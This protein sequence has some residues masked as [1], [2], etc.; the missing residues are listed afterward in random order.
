MADD[1]TTAAAA[2]TIEP[3]DDSPGVVAAF[4]SVWRHRRWRWLA[5][6]TVVSLFGDV[7]YVVA[8]A[9]SL[10]DGPNGAVWLAGSFL[11]R[12]VPYVVLGPIGGAIADRIDRRLLMV[13]L[14]FA[15][16]CLFIAMAGVAVTSG[17]RLAMVI[18]LGLNA[19]CGAVFEP[20]RGAAIPQLVPERD[21][22]A[23]NATEQGLS[24]LSWFVGPALGALLVAV[25]NPGI[26][27]AIDA[28]TFFIS[29]VLL[30]RV[31]SL[32]PMPRE[33][34]GA[35]EPAGV[36]ATVIDDIGAGARFAFRDRGLRGLMILSAIAT[37]AFGAE[38]ILYVLVAADRLGLG[39]EGIGYLLT[40]MGVGGIIG[41]PLSARASNSRNI[42]VWLIATG[43]LVSV[44]MVVVSLTDLRWVVFG[45]S[46][47]EGGAAVVFDVVVL[48][49]MQR[50]VPENAMGRVLSLSDALATL[51]Q[52][53][54][55]IGAPLLVSVAGL[56]IALQV[57]G[58]LALAV[59]LITAPALLALAARTE[60]ERRRLNATARHLAVVAELAAFEPIDLERLA[61]ASSPLSVSAGADVITAGDP[62]GDVYV[63]RTGR[64]E[65][66]A[67][68]RPAGAG[69]PPILGAGSLFGEIGILRGIPR[70][71]TVTALDDTELLAI[72]GPVFATV[73]T[74]SPATEQLFG[75]M[76]SRLH[77]THPHLVEPTDA[78][79]P[80]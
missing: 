53:V 43:V 9:V 76:R 8:I 55:A 42:G 29:A 52:T 40:A 58:G 34:S 2:A 17:P 3:D 35:A 67:A 22:A 15:R 31:G 62:P 11:A 7:M 44:P 63:V 57:S 56:T 73:A 61:R 25:S 72:D 12:L 45:M 24:Q 18:L 65:V 60:S 54:G 51:G 1:D 4:R 21:L 37:L 64:L 5:A 77:H 59:V 68:D 27:L 47:I 48:T 66:T 23:A 71:A 74:P 26:V 30:A 36:L 50:A 32:V 75:G 78:G 33:P 19:A 80:S 39:A 13:G 69:P 70:T 49:L 20:A 16:G 10:L 6:S 14:A 46:A 41:A 38:Q 79:A 28:A